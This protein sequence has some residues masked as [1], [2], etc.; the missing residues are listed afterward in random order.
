MGVCKKNEQFKGRTNNTCSIELLVLVYFLHLMFPALC[1]YI[2]L[3]ALKGVKMVENICQSLLH[4]K[5]VSLQ[6]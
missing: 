1:N 3:D 2:K 6:K 4:G 5:R